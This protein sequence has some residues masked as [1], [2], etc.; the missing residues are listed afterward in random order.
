VTAAADWKRL[1]WLFGS[2][3]GG[4]GVVTGTGCPP[5]DAGGWW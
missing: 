2:A 5:V 1:R 4:V 3:M